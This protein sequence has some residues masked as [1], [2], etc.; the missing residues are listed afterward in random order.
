MKNLRKWWLLK[1]IF[2]IM[3][4]SLTPSLVKVVFLKWIPVTP[5]SFTTFGQSLSRLMLI[6]RII[7]LDYHCQFLEP[8][9]TP[10]ILLCDKIYR[11]IYVVNNVYIKTISKTTTSWEP[12]HLL[13]ESLCTTCPDNHRGWENW[14]QNLCVLCQPVF[15]CHSVR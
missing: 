10:C 15:L 4:H 1:N 7:C 9:A 13:A 12:P 5:N 2:R 3:L 6:G 8:V 11:P 14:I